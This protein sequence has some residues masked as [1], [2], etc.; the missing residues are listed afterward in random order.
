M[1]KKVMFYSSSILFLNLLAVS[2]S[3]Q[4]MLSKALA[5]LATLDFWTAYLNT[6][7]IMDFV[8]SFVLMENL[9]KDILKK[10]EFP[11]QI[12]RV[13]AIIFSLGV[14]IALDKLRTNL[15]YFM[16]PIM[17]LGVGFYLIKNFTSENKMLIT[18]IGFLVMAK[19]MELVKAMVPAA[20]TFPFW[21]LIYIAFYA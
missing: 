2:V 5:P 19:I 4:N 7:S 9:F 15:V 20:G 1:K 17:L 3:A 11:P 10:R 16:W 14:V 12:I 21:D 6:S 18:G 8:L 13:L